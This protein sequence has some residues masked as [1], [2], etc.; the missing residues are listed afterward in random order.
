MKNIIV[1]TAGH[2][3]H[4]KTCLIKALT[5]TDTD[6]LKEEKK[7]GIT[8]ENGFADL[9]YGE[10]NIS[11]IDVPG[12]ERFIKNML[13]G[14]GGVDLVL[15]V[16][17]LD[18]GVMPQTAEHLQILD[19]LKIAGGVIVFT[20]RDLVEDE[21]WIELVKEDVAALVEGTFL[22]GAP[23]IEV[24]AFE[25]RRIEELKRLIAEN[26][27]G[28]G[29]R[30][31]SEELFRLPVDR[32]FTARGFGTVITG[33]LLEG[34]VNTGEELEVYPAETVA[35]A[36]TIQVHNETVDTARAG[37]RTAINLT[38]LKKEELHRGQVLARKGSMEPSM[39]LDV[40]LELFRDAGRQVASGSRVHFYCGS[41]EVLS[42]VILLDRE[43]AEQGCACYAQLRLEDRVAVKRGDRFIIRFY[44]PVVTIGGGKV[45]DACPKKR[46]RYDPRALSAMA[47]K[48]TGS[49]EEVLLLTAE[50]NGGRMAMRRDLA[51]K[52]RLSEVR[53]EELLRPLL[54]RGEL[55][56]LRGE[57]VV[58][59]SYLLNACE[60]GKAI[61]SAYHEA[62]AL[63]A[64]MPKEEFKSRLSRA[65]RL[66]DGKAVED[67][68]SAM[69]EAGQIRCSEKTTALRDFQIRYT[70][71]AEAMRQRLLQ[72]YRGKRF[73]FPSMEEALSQEKDKA[74]AG[75]LV[76][77]LAEEGRLVRLDYRYFIDR[78]AYDWALDRLKRAVEENGR[79]TLAEFRDILG[80]SRK[81]AME[82]LEYLDKQK[83][84]K[85]VGDARV[86]W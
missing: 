6:R 10:Y 21:E 64:G 15:L 20:K 40:R 32:V 1:G 13:A 14:I 34:A 72:L 53:M 67:I 48:D 73:S 76:E 22:E 41:A 68:V 66:A 5:G 86:L 56:L 16:V 63:S 58:H 55:Y 71:E 28:S 75:R 23:S 29:L 36:R 24:S 35:R 17:A 9:Q 3:D 80:T 2:V 31:D 65:L 47:V 82:I 8:I 77:A 38:G 42:K 7:R 11:F 12:H 18:E 45:L 57:Y 52:L 49:Q 70:P 30:D 33:T 25:N 50:E 69:E 46:K 44:S 61:L 74:G 39:M 54:E 19:M 79:I 81:Y 83:I 43:T 84:T 37:Q 85:K 26:I 51:A 62:N 4:G 60:R 59:R 78:E 27:G